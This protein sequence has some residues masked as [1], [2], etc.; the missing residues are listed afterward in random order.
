[1]TIRTLGLVLGLAWMM[2]SAEMASAQRSGFSAP[3]SSSSG[4]LNA[5]TGTS[6]QGNQ[7]LRA[8]GRSSRD[9]RTR[10]LGQSVGLGEP[11]AQPQGREFQERSFVGRDAEDVRDTFRNLTRGQRRRAMMD[12]VV[13]NLNEMR[14]SRRRWRD[15]QRQPPSVR[16]Q[17]RPAFDYPGVAVDRVALEVQTRLT[18]VMRKRGLT[19]PSVDLQ[20][21]TATLR[22]SVR[23][24]HEKALAGQIVALEPGVSQVENLL[25]VAEE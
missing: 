25:V 4:R 5:R 7:G 18:A 8:G 14:E 17:L 12:M 23:S 6:R 19:T 3:G 24:A 15:Q 2:S 20:G 16:V 9:G 10:G 13:E 1:M 22:G 11:S 21:R